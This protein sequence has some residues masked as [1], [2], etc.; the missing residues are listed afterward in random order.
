M[1]TDVWANVLLAAEAIRE[2]L[3]PL[4]AMELLASLFLYAW[5]FCL[6]ATFGSFL[7]VVVYRLPRRKN[8]AYPGSCCP[9]CGHAIR[10]QDN[11]PI[12]SWLLLRG[13]CR[14][15][16]GPISARYFLVELAV[17]SLLLGVA[18]IETKFTGTFPRRNW[19]ASRWL[20][21]PYDT[22]PF[23][24]AYGLHVVLL[25]TLLGAAL[26]DYDGYPVPRGLF[27]P[28]VLAGLML[29]TIWPLLRHPPALALGIADLHFAALFE[30]T[31]SL[32]L[33]LL[34]GGAIGVMWRTVS[35][36][37]W[38]RF[39]PVALLATVGAAVSWQHVLEVSA[40]SAVVF[41]AAILVLPLGS[42]NRIVPFAGIAF[43]AVIPRLLNLDLR[44]SS[45]LV[46]PP[47]YYV[48]IGLICFAVA[49]FAAGI[50]ARMA[51]PQYFAPPPAPPMSSPPLPEITP[52]TS[53]VDIPPQ[54]LPPPP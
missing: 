25:T 39:A 16:Q 54:E 50:A 9:H 46:W 24:S 2:P 5:L 7:N 14:D 45:P 1:E 32:G 19:D 21:S 40:A 33:G 8:L 29:P 28:A 49:A 37:G 42:A 47:N 51:P 20:I 22:L 35:G 30:G 34:C 3:L 41:A 27:V 15:C 43:V 26:I 38:P 44:F 11:I 48:G 18:L 31:I 12:V 4:W 52:E 10:L 13:R 17:A 23:W 53:A 36:R 6:G